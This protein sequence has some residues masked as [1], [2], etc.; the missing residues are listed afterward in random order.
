MK[1]FD[2]SCLLKEQNEYEGLTIEQVEEL[3]KRKEN[4][5]EGL[6]ERMGKEL[7]E[8]EVLDQMKL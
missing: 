7:N 6:F 8:A 4:Q 3:I 2:F 5:F 1:E